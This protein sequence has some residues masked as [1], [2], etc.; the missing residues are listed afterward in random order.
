M[1][2][3]QNLSYYVAWNSH[4]WSLVNR[5]YVFPI[6]ENVSGALYKSFSTHLEALEYYKAKKAEGLVNIA[7]DPG[8]DEVFGPIEDAIQ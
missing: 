3:K 7:R 4:S 8:D 2:G 5:V 1:S 6:V